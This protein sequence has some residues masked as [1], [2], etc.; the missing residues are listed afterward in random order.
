[1]MPGT[2][3]DILKAAEK[4]PDTAK[5]AEQKPAEGA[6]QKPAVNQPVSRGTSEQFKA[7][8]GERKKTG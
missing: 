8:Y 1:M 5:P 4:P 6:E 3:D 7:I 2:F